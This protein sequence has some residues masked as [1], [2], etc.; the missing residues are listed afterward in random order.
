MRP[1]ASLEGSVPTR[2]EP[3]TLVPKA[4]HR[5]GL[6]HGA[7]RAGPAGVC[8]HHRGSP[9][10][11]VKSEEHSMT[12]ESRWLALFVFVAVAP[13]LQADQLKMRTAAVVHGTWR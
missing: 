1:N 4:S 8:L 7:N 10:P 13:A 3:L 6:H 2:T 12:K 11:H 5:S 9:R